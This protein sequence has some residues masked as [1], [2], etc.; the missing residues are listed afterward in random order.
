MANYDFD[1]AVPSAAELDFETLI[2]MQNAVTTVKPLPR[3]PAIN[4]DLSLIVDESTTWADIVNTVNE[5]APSQLENIRFMGIYRGK[6]IDDGKK[7][8]TLSLRFRDED[9]TLTHE[10]VDAIEKTI[11]NNLAKTVNAKLRTI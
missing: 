9:G 5:N 6:G 7:S 3:Y 10:S 2:Q 4:R 8:L 11:V 1:S